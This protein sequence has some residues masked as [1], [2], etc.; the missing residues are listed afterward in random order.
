[1]SVAD[2]RVRLISQLSSAE[3]A[4]LADFEG[5]FGPCTLEEFPQGIV[6]AFTCDGRRDWLFLDQVLILEYGEH[7]PDPDGERR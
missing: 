3:A 5:R 1:M 2:D 4:K 6:V 7:G